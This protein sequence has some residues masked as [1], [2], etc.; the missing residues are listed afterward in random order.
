MRD[1]ISELGLQGQAISQPGPSPAQNVLPE[2]G[3]GCPPPPIS[4]GALVGAKLSKAGHEIQA[5]F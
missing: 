2:P 3:K 1:V 5:V 4:A